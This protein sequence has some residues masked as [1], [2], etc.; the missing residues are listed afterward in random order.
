MIPSRL[1]RATQVPDVISNQAWELDL[2]SDKKKFASKESL[3]RLNHVS[4]QITFERA[5]LD[6]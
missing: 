1:Y 2:A 5:L 6:G 4:A 3:S